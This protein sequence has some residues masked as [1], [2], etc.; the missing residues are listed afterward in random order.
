MLNY[1]RKLIFESVRVALSEGDNP[2]SNTSTPERFKSGAQ[3][4]LGRN[5]LRTDVGNHA[6]N[7]ET[8]LPSTF[9]TNGANFVGEPITLSENMFN[10]YKIKNFGN[11]E[12]K[13]TLS[14]FGRG[15]KA[16]VELRRAI[17]TLNGAAT[18]NGKQLKYRTISSEKNKSR[19]GMANTFWEFSYN[20][21]DWY[22]L[23]PNPVQDMK[24]SK[25]IRK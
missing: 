3:R 2:Y 16:E 8:L 4:Q 15:A 24:L 20:G 7:T 21:E 17:D 22:I 11:V 25:L 19:R 5:P 10:V 1:I 23:K 18:R 9:D 13:D 14:L 12:I 6:G